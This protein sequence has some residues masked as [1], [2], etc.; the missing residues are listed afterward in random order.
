MI[1]IIWHV[2]SYPNYNDLEYILDKARL[3]DPV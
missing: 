3:Q 2:A 1:A